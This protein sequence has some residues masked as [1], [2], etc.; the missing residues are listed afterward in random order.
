VIETNSAFLDIAGIK[1]N[2]VIGRDCRELE[3]LS[4][5]WNSITGSMLSG[6]EQTER[7]TFKNLVLDVFITPILVDGSINY[8]CIMMRDV[9]SYVNLENEMFKRNKELIITNALS[10]TFISSNDIGSVYD[11]LLERVMTISDMTIG[12]IIIREANRFEIKSARGASRIFKEKVSSGE[13]DFLCDDILKTGDPLNVLEEDDINDIDALKNEGI[14]FLS[15]IPL[16]YGGEMFGAVILAS[17]VRV[18]MDFDFVSL[19]SLIGNNLSLITEK[20]KLFQETRRLSVTDSLTGLYN[21]RHFYRMLESETARSK[22]YSEHF[23]IILFDI[24]NFKRVNDSFGHQ[25]GDNVLVNVAE[26]LVKTSRQVDTVARYGGEEFVKILPNTPK[27]E[28]YKLGMRVKNALEMHEYLGT[29]SVKITLSGGIA[30]YPEDA[31]E[32][33]SLLYAAD[34]AMYKAKNAGKNQI[35]LYEEI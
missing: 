31:D 23:S 22:R 12:W 19:L 29:E 35:C 10:S 18:G 11:D 21:L 17:R 34:M 2:I 27:K 1:E 33:K 32:A 6:K 7:V 28:A 16:R 4:S 15:V 24:D 5:I 3:P 13:L 30:S 9:S 8:A 20:I 14:A 25:A 26:I